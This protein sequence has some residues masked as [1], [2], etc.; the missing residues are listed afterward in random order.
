MRQD[1]REGTFT[2]L[3][4]R[5]TVHDTVGG[6][7]FHPDDNPTDLVQKVSTAV[8]KR[9]EGETIVFAANDLD[10]GK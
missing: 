1:D 3:F 5:K 6:L 10:A 9:L 2:Q 4:S 8:F 7:L